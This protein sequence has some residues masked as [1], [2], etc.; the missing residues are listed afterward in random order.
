[1]CL[2]TSQALKAEKKHL[3][4][5]FDNE[6][7]SVSIPFS[8]YKNLII[9]EAVLDNDQKLN[10]ILDTGIRSLVLFDQSYIPKVSDNTFDIEFS[11]A[12]EPT[13]IKAIVS[14]GHDLRLSTDVV[15]NQINAVLLDK[16]NRYLHELGGIKVDGAFGYQLFARFQVKID[17]G[18]QMITLSE[19]DRSPCLK[20]FEQ[21]PMSIHDTKPFIESS[22]LM[23]KN[24]WK[25]FTLLLDLGANH[26][27]LLLDRHNIKGTVGYISDIQRIAEGL[28]GSIYGRKGIAKTIKIG[29]V[30]FNNTEMLLPTKDTYHR[31]S[32]DGVSKQGSIGGRFF[33]NSTV[34]LDYINGLFYIKSPLNCP[35]RKIC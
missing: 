24:L 15:A 6:K 13:P 18:N 2:V 21:V 25:N 9:I 3:G 31:E 12:G 26:K 33:E 10:L 1:M 14:I 29:N 4:F 35:E 28:G 34:I 5:G 17:Y 20:G 23:S 11:G 7:V 16:S 32:I 19:P 30:Q 27:I 8:S 22:F